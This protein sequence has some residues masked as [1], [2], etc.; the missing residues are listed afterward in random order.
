LGGEAQVRDR[1]VVTLLEGD[2]QIGYFCVPVARV[3]KSEVPEV[4]KHHH[5]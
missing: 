1:R 3:Y 4:R 2:G 5:E